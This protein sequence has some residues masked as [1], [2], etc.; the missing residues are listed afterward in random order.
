M[1]IMWIT[2]WI[3]KKSVENTS[4]FH[5]KSSVCKIKIYQHLFP[6]E[7]VEKNVD[8]VDNYFSSSS[9]PM[10][11]TFPA[12]IVINRSSCIHFFRTKSSIDLKSGR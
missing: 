1:W 4:F 7:M 3:N 5:K 2:W 9:S 6:E 12:P 8:N 10:V 11:T